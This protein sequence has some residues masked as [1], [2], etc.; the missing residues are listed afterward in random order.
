M[1]IYKQ[2]IFS[3]KSYPA[4]AA[5]IVGLLLTLI[6]ANQ[7]SRE[8]KKDEQIKFSLMCDQFTTQVKERFNVHAQS[9]LGT[10]AKIK[11]SDKIDADEFKLFIKDLQIDKF[12]PGIYGIGINMVVRPGSLG[13]FKKD[14]PNIN[15]FPIGNRPFYTPIIYLEPLNSVNKQA[16]GFDTYSN[17]IRQKA[18]DLAITSGTIALT[19]KVELIQDKNNNVKPA[20]FILFAPVFKKNMPIDTIEQRR[21][22]I[23]AFVYSPI[24]M[25]KLLEG[26]LTDS[27]ERSIKLRVYSNN[28]QPPS[29]ENLLY[30]N[31]KYTVRGNQTLLNQT[32]TLQFDNQVSWLLKFQPQNTQ[33]QF[34]Y[35]PVWITCI[36]GGL[37][38][39]LG[40]LLSLS[41][42]HI[43][44]EAHVLAQAQT[45]Q[46]KLLND[47]LSLA[48]NSAKM[49]V[50]D[51]DL[52]NNSLSWDHQQFALYDMDESSFNNLVDDWES[53]VYPEDR[54]KAIQAVN[55]AIEGKKD[56]D[57]EFRI[58]HRNG[59]IRT[60]AGQ[61]VI[62][63]DSEK[64]P[65]RMIGVNYDITDL[66][67]ASKE[68]S[69]AKIRAE[70]ASLA[71]SQFLATMSHEIRTPLNG[72]IGTSSLA[73]Q[74]PLAEDIKHHFETI[75]VSSK[76]LLT[77][78]NQILEFSKIEANK[79][80][81]VNEPFEFNQLLDDVY[82]L[83]Y[84]SCRLKNIDLILDLDKKI[85]HQLIG[86]IKN[87]Q[88]VLFNLVG[89]AVKFTSTGSVTIKTQFNG[90]HN[91][92]VDFNISVID[93]GIGIPKEDFIRIL[94]PFEQLDAR[95]S[96]EFG[97][98]GLGLTISQEILF[99]MNSRLQMESQFGQ[100]SSFGFHLNLEFI[101]E[102]ISPPAF[103]KELEHD[104]QAPVIP[105]NF[106]GINILI[107][108]DNE[109]NLQIVSQMLQTVHA[110]VF[111]ARNGL[112]CL[113]LLL[114]NSVDIIL[115][116]VQMPLM[117]GLEATKKI[118]DMN[119]F[120]HLPIIGLSAVV[121]QQDQIDCLKAG[122][123]DFMPKPFTMD[124]VLSKI[125][126][127]L[128]K[129][130]S[131]I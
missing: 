91:Q 70:A 93:T 118:R 71:K 51:Y 18:Q 62:L 43:Q 101:D 123:S 1:K 55:L 53:A 69:S 110:N 107:V 14:Y 24:R 31:T 12:S 25:E 58:I 3:K 65:T 100:G 11:S 130:H 129:S 98:T 86:D 68:L 111:H 50:W 17:P 5:L 74:Q 59:A 16:I 66:I 92:Y 44:E 80:T 40:F 85:P 57:I 22:A 60:L 131:Q 64:N 79:L 90:I 113:D 32:R 20:S 35:V 115:M 89:N 109:I 82:N 15:I 105:E 128:T 21:G 112:E 116:D 27:F 19:D 56:Y 75:S 52:I 29:S 6:T 121:L 103:A 81:L 77:I 2:I 87:I 102:P 9:V 96:R 126:P 72:I 124:D 23:K 84:S 94:N 78:L 67:N 104:L 54:D 28:N 34:M 83:F 41:R 4:W 88:Q 33:F 108:E 39:L 42:T 10:A 48:L 95:T 26:L 120:Q 47:R 37:I 49:G 125:Y 117:D 7:I 97:G 76:A 46:I 114:K 30:E 127:W 36:V 8:I 73:L 63:R 61:A 99:L 38:S 45:S 122:M 106:N 119:Q 13:A